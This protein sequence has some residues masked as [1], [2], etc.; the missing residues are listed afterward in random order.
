MKWFRE[1]K[2]AT[3]IASILA[4]LLIITIVSF[5]YPGSDSWLG[6]KVQ[7]GLA[8][9]QEPVNSAGNGVSSAFKG[10]FRFRSIMAENEELKEEI[11]DLERELMEQSLSAADLEELRALSEVLNY[12]DISTS[13]RWVTADVIAMDGSQWFNI[14]T[15]NAG[16]DQGLQKDAV[17]LNGDGLIGKIYEVGPGWSKV[18]SVIDENNHVSFRANRDLNLLGILSGDGKG[19]LTG[20]MLDPE[21]SI[22]EGDVLIT[23]GMELYPEGIVIG[24]VSKVEWNTDSLRKNVKIEPAVYFKNISKVTVVIPAAN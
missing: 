8:F 7:S 20:Y 6:K 21:A 19:G 18:I 12:T 13:Y 2:K 24:K 1:H 5:V 11:A 10:I 3:I 15:I 17:V 14:F 23:S 22:I 4:V 9:L 16:S